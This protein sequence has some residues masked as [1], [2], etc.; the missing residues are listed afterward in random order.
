M[1]YNRREM[2]QNP[3]RWVV[4]SVVAAGVFAVGLVMLVQSR[5]DRAK[6]EAERAASAM[7][8]QVERADR[9]RT[10]RLDAAAAVAERFIGHVGAGRWAEA[11][12]LLATPYRQAVSVDAFARTCRSSPLLAGA[13]RV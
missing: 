10:A 3:M 1:A 13:R 11:Y 9:E 8:E 2:E 4:L 7:S 6:A 12:A 5:E